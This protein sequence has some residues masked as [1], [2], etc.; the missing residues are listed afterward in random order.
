MSG[1][2]YTSGFFGSFI[3]RTVQIVVL[4]MLIACT[5]A[6]VDFPSF[7]LLVFSKP[8]A[9]KCRHLQ[10]YIFLYFINLF[11]TMVTGSQNS[12]YSIH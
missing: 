1:H 5:V 6:L 4:D 10:L 9:H 2:L 7:S 8:T 3:P 11:T 12:L